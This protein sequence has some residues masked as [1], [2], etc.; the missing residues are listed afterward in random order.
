MNKLLPIVTMALLAGCGQSAPA[1]DK[2]PAAAAP[3]GPH[4]NAAP[5]TFVLT[6]ADGSMTTVFLK[7]DG[8]YTDWVAG[9]MT[10]SGKWAVEDNKT[11]YHPDQG[12]ARC[13]VDSPVGPDG[14]Y[15]ETPDE[16]APYKVSKTA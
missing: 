8:T 14:S 15:T 6:G 13:S 5:G 9:G 7:A 3:A 1:G 2:T 10:E 16:G 12:K 4:S 11:C